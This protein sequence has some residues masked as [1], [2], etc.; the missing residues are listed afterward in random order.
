MEQQEKTKGKKLK[1]Q[2]SQP[3]PETSQQVKRTKEGDSPSQDTAS[4]P[5]IRMQ[6]L[7]LSLRITPTP[8]EPQHTMSYAA[9]V[10]R[11][12]AMQTHTGVGPFLTVGATG[13]VPNWPASSGGQ[14]TTPGGRSS[15]IGG[16]GLGQ[17]TSTQPTTGQAGVGPFGRPGSAPT[18]GSISG[19]LKQLQVPQAAL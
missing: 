1:R 5:R 18:E 7:E 10:A 14:Q 9:T 17:G 13:S 4:Y 8:G 3:I 16:A 11:T 2:T 6:T 19:G 12:S 15:Q